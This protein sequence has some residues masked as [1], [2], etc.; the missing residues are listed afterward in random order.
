MFSCFRNKVVLCFFLFVGINAFKAQKIDIN[1]YENK[2]QAYA[3]LSAQYSAD[4]YAYSRE[5]FFLNDKTT[6]QFNCDTAITY[7]EIAMQYAD[8]AL[9][10]ADDSSKYA[11]EVMLYAIEYQEKAIMGWQKIK[12]EDRT[13]IIHNTS[14]E[15]IY[16]ISN[17]V[18][19][20]Y[21]ASLEFGNKIRKLENTDVIADRD[22]TRL[23]IDEYAYK[24]AQTTY[25]KKIDEIDGEILLL[26]DKK[27]SKEEEK[28]I[29]DVILE[30]EAEKRQFLGKIKNSE[31]KLIDIKN[32]L[33]EEMLKVVNKDNFTTNKKG[34]YSEEVPIPLNVELPKGLVY[35]IQIGFFKT[36]VPS[37]NFDGIFPISCEQI[38]STYYKYLVGNFNN[39]QEAKAAKL[40]MIE[41]GYTD[42]FVTSYF[43]GEKIPVSKALKREGK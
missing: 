36:R 31:S 4:A 43:D 42:A 12:R 34:F 39:Y 37:N 32:K 30:L 28:L 16:F 7:T 40:I 22:I 19:D 25:L 20:A 27:V 41:I 13:S 11:K 26:K 23:E 21:E 10:V 6:I 24:N 17:A 2:A 33:S 1:L 14:E 8:S 38:N 29:D 35:K 3:I 5:S 9:L 18:V 15:T